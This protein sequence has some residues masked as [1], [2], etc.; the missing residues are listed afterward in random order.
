[1]RNVAKLEGRNPNDL[2]VLDRGAMI[3]RLQNDR[4]YAIDMAARHV[5]E[6]ILNK[7]YPGY[8]GEGLADEQVRTIGYGYNLGYP[9]RGLD[10]DNPDPKRIGNSSY[11]PDLLGK[12]GRMRD[13]LK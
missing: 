4:P 8:D 12:L 7:A 10:P 3:N 2:N 6:E 1:M 11:G 13:L 9:H 5:R